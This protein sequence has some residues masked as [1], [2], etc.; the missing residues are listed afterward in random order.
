[1]LFALI[2]AAALGT[3][4]VQIDRQFW[5][6]TARLPSTRRAYWAR[7]ALTVAADG[8]AVACTVTASSGERKLDVMVCA[9]PLHSARFQPARDPD[10]NPVAAIVEQ[11]FAVNM[12]A[13][14]RPPERHVDYAVPIDRLP[15]QANNPF[16]TLRIVIEPSGHIA[17]CVVSG[18]SGN[19]ALDALACPA[20][21][22]VDV[23][24]V[25]TAAGEAAR[26]MRDLTIAF[27]IKAG[28]QASPPS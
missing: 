5:F 21:A 19:V 28:P 4:P 12:A 9:M 23:Q 13:P 6:N 24:P 11:E 27:V 3:M 2:A 10:G 1:M 14:A 18:S 26:A 22:T 20:I 16:V 8:L 17:R 25:R 7:T 15:A